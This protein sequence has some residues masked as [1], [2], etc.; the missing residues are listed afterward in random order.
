M[1]INLSW[2]VNSLE[3]CT[4]ASNY[5]IMDCNF[6]LNMSESIVIIVQQIE[7]HLHLLSLKHVT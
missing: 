3:T 4:H 2:K 7:V 6:N 1:R 5:D